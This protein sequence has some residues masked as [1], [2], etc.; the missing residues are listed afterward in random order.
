MKYYLEYEIL[1]DRPGLLG[2][3]TSLIGMLKI[4]IEKVSSIE[5]HRRGFLLNYSSDQQMEALVRSLHE[6]P[7]LEIKRTGTPDEFDLLT[8]KHG[9]RIQNCS[10]NPTEPP[11]YCFERKELDY[12][13]DFL[14]GLLERET[15]LLIGL[16][17]SPRI[18]K[19]ETA[20]AASVHANKPWLLVSSTLFKKIVRTQ[21]DAELLQVKPV[22]IIDA[23]TTFRRSFPEHIAF[24][25]RV[26]RMK[27]LR[28]VEHPDLLIREADIQLHDF[29]LIVEIT[30]TGDEASRRESKPYGFTNYDIS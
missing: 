21:I 28:I 2:D 29:D 8:L 9:K 3:V 1:N 10:L 16:R 19:S 24:V 20:I 15:D 13:I 17:G 22:L 27:A 23:I 26:L 5:G 4:N 7:D 18:G 6:V 30:A 12:L 11:I 14:G 25:K